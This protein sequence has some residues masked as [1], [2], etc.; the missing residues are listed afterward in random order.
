MG[1]DGGPGCGIVGALTWIED[2]WHD[3][4]R[5]EPARGRHFLDPRPDPGGER[6]AAEAHVA[7][8]RHALPVHPPRQRAEHRPRVSRSYELAFDNGC[9]GDLSLRGGA[10][11]RRPKSWSA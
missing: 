2:R 5:A 8:R 9:A 4:A 7:L 10:F 6:A 11:L 1:R 3:H